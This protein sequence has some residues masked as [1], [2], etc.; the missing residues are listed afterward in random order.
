MTYISGPNMGSFR[1]GIRNILTGGKGAEVGHAPYYYV[2]KILFALLGLQLLGAVHGGWLIHRW[3]NNSHVIPD[4][5]I[6]RRIWHI[7]LPIVAG[8]LLI[9]F[10][11][12]VLPNQ[13]DMTLRGMLAFAP[14]ATYLVFAGSGFAVIWGA[15]RALKYRKLLLKTNTGNSPKNHES[16]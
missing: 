8:A 4:N 13:F 3:K 16:T 10:Y 11:L 6:G 12:Y 2:L 5:T 1:W 7:C 9:V 15:I 14:D